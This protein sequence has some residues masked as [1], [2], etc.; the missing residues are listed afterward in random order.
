MAI[1]ESSVLLNN[2]SKEY[3]PKTNLSSKQVVPKLWKDPSTFAAKSMQDSWYTAMFKL[4]S[5][6]FHLSVDFFG[7]RMGYK[8]LVVPITTNSISSP[9]GLGSDSQPVSI[10]LHGDKT[11]IA[12]SQQFVLEY[13]LRLEDGLLGAYYVGTS[14]RGE[15]HDATHLNQFCH[16]ECEL[17]GDLNNGIGVANSYV[18]FLV[19][20]LLRDH[21]SEIKAYA[22]TT[23][24]LESLLALFRNNGN[25]FPT[26]NLDDALN[27]PEMKSDMWQYAVDGQPQFGRCLTR[28]GERMLIEKFGGA[29]WLME[30]DHLSVPFYQSY[31][32][33]GLNKAKCG[34]LL[35]GLGEVV[36]CGE[37]HRT[38]EEALQALDQHEVSP[39]DYA[40]YLD[41]RAIKPLTSTGW[42]IGTERF[43]SWVMQHND[44]RDIQLLPRLKGATCA[45]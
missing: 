16:V 7:Q 43:L 36:G 44:I 33:D 18:V 14:A 34:D 20:G 31:V 24:H 35:L 41:M 9:M 19:E 2:R 10:E 32:G 12:D 25:Q 1:V 27:L 21:A 23:S 5:T 38:K 29:C 4:Q 26:I 45:P 15:D 30:M 13:A 11:Y 22:G 8:Y 39:L 40:W 28:K 17:V 37:R 3:E 6:L 42:G